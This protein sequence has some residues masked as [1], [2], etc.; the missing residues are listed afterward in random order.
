[1]PVY[2]QRPE[3]A[4]KRANGECGRAPRQ[5]G[6]GPLPRL[7][8]R[9][10]E[11]WHEAPPPRRRCKAGPHVTARLPPEGPSLMERV[12]NATCGAGGIKRILHRRL[13]AVLQRRHVVEHVLSV[14]TRLSPC[15]QGTSRGCSW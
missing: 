15:P 9:E 3:N 7:G 8:P 6:S 2:F 12:G 4:L 5:P 11:A 1:M 13:L 10:A 14:L